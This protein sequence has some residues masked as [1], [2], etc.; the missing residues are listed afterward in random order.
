MGKA[1]QRVFV[2]RKNKANMVKSRK[3]IAAT[4]ETLR[5]LYAEL[6]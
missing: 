5:K 3:I 2:R 1:K 6:K 4:Q